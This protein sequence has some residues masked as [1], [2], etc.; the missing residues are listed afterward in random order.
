MVKVLIVDEEPVSEVYAEFLD[1]KGYEVLTASTASEALKVLGQNQDITQVITELRLPG[2]HGADLI[3]T[4][5]K[6]YSLVKVFVCTAD[7]SCAIDLKRR[8]SVGLIT[9]YILKPHRLQEL[10]D[11]LDH[12]K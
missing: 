7:H 2:I 8:K 10:S 1:F 12:N 3:H 9:G 6:N 5:R 4:I 11:Y